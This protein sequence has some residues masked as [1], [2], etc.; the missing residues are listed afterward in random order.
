MN[1][2]GL[3]VLALI[4]L[5]SVVLA[6]GY[7]FGGATPRRAARRGRCPIP[8]CP[9]CELATLTTGRIPR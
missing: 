3:I 7:V 1:V 9:M 5:P 8:S 2:P 4:S 6:V